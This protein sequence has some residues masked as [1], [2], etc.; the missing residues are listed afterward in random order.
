MSL[1]V[2]ND[3]FLWDLYSGSTE[4]KNSLCYSCISL[5]NDVFHKKQLREESWNY[6]LSVNT[7]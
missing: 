6:R 7:V 3:L 4:S 1:D 2:L 5:I